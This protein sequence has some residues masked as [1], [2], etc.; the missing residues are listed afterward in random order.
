MGAGKSRRR[1]TASVSSVEP[2]STIT[3]ACTRPRSESRHRRMTRHSFLT[4]RHAATVIGGPPRLAATCL[5]RA[6]L[7]YALSL[8]KL[9]E[10]LNEERRVH[11][12][13]RASDPV[14]ESDRAAGRRV[15]PQGQDVAGIQV[16]DDLAFGSGVA[17]SR[18]V[19][20]LR[21]RGAVHKQRELALLLTRHI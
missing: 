21:H 4:I 1:I 9:C 5:L 16:K 19:Q 2:V 18:R 17:G 3:T 8:L 12:R 15:V 7:N 20:G 10:L 6:V 14:V 11:V 13:L